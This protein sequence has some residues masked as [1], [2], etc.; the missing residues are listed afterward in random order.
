M[1]MKIYELKCKVKEL[2]KYDLPLVQYP[3][4]ILLALQ[5]IFFYKT[6]KI[7]LSVELASIIHRSNWSGSESIAIKIVQRIFFND[8]NAHKNKKIFMKQLVKSIERKKN[9]EKFFED[10][11]LLF[12]GTCIFLK[13]Y[14]K[15]QKGV[16]L[17]KYS[18]YFPLLFKF[19]D[20]QAMSKQYHII[21]EPSWAGI[22]EPGILAYTTL[23]EPVFVMAY[24]ERDARFLDK[25]S[26]NL[27][28]V[29]IG[30]N[31]WVDHRNFRPAVE[32][33]K[34]IDVIVISSWADFKRH[35]RIF[36][37]LRKVKKHYPNLRVALVG[38]NTSMTLDD[39]RAQA[40]YY[41]VEDLIEFHHKIPTNEVGDLLRRSKINLL[42]SRFEGS[43]RTII[44]GMFS[45]VPCIIRHGFN[46]GM[47]Y[48]FI[49]SKTGIW[50][51][52]SSLADNIMYMM[53]NYQ[54][55]SPREYVMQN[56]T[57]FLATEILENTINEH[58]SNEN[59]EPLRDLAV[60]INLLDHMTY[61]ESS[62]RTLFESDISGV[63]SMRLPA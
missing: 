44:E 29:S 30:A 10:P 14:K 1:K 23:D 3:L 62:D 19:Y 58:Y 16:L 27:K 25:I 11:D 21:L 60:K 6:K 56:H 34:S 9:T 37:A 22:C 40:K 52:E 47:K 63:R 20:M 43:P 42:W 2:I 8:K 26:T 17:I 38:Y 28:A 55:F 31:W 24:E 35:Y 12:D 51:K 32:E 46:Y 41:G 15:G 57:C 5:A 7:L 61:F 13:S 45:N 59:Q 36:V 48:P 39:I 53:E 18:Y 33:A 49:N 54:N 50:S 4:V